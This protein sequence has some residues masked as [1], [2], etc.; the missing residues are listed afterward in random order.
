MFHLLHVKHNG[1]KKRAS[2][3]RP[4]QSLIQLTDFLDL[5]FQAMV[6]LDPVFHH[7]FLLRAKADVPDLAPWFADRQNQHRMALATFAFRTPGFVA[8]RALQQ[9]STQQLGSGEVGGQF[10]ASSDDVPMFHYI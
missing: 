10:V 2:G 3:L 8:N 4:Q 6:V 9:R 5:V 1:R 7:R